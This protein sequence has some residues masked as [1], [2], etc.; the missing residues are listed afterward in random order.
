MG[1]MDPSSLTHGIQLAIAPV[2]LLTAVAALITAVAARLA[3][4][5]D[6]ARILEERLEAQMINKPALAHAELDQL[7][8]RAR[9]VNGAMALLTLCAVLIGATVMALFLGE[10]TALHATRLVSICFLS[11]IICFILAL[12]S[13]LAETVLASETLKFGRH[14][15]R[16]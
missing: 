15:P 8:R 1:R 3:R 13:F 6:R 7:K 11:G 10:T 4:I 16:G 5:I 12:L 14:L 2:F 9:L